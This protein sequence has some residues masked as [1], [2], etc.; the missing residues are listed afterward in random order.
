V[1]LEPLWVL[2]PVLGLTVRREVKVGVVELMDGDAGREML[3]RF[4][5]PLDGQFSD[6]L[7]DVGSFARVAVPAKCLYDAE[8]EGRGLIDDATA[9]L[10]IRLRYSWS[11]GPDQRLEPYQRATTLVVV[12]RLP[13]VAVFPV[14]GSGRRWWRE[15]PCPARAARRTRAGRPVARPPMPT[16]VSPSDRQALMRSD[17]RS[18]PATQSSG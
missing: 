16:Y 1:A 4:V 10:T 17:G 9:W 15:R 11:H 3:R 7:A 12:E 14:E 5:P 13:G 6:P 18:R 2:A 8:R